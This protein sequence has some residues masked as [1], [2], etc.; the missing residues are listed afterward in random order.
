MHVHAICDVIIFA[1]SLG[2]PVAVPKALKGFLFA[3][4]VP[5]F[6]ISISTALTRL[7]GGSNAAL[8]WFHKGSRRVCRGILVEY[9]TI[10]KSN[11]IGSI[12][13]P[14]HDWHTCGK[15]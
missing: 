8:S 6:V 15:T 1:V 7:K 4:I 11:C 13:Q 2:L 14:W 9:D 12:L 3:V 10:M 5:Q